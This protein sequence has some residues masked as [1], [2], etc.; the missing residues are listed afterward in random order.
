MKTCANHDDDATRPQAHHNFA[1]KQIERNSHEQQGISRCSLDDRGGPE[2]SGSPSISGYHSGGHPVSHR[3]F[4][5]SDSGVRQRSRRESMPAR[6][7][8]EAHA[9]LGYVH[10]IWNRRAVSAWLRS[11]QMYCRM[12]QLADPGPTSTTAEITQKPMPINSEK[13]AAAAMAAPKSEIKTTEPKVSPQVTCQEWTH[14]EKG[15]TI[16]AEP[17]RKLKRGSQFSSGD[18]DRDQSATSSTIEDSN[19]NSG[20]RGG[21]RDSGVPDR[22]RGERE[23]IEKAA[24]YIMNDQPP[25][26]LTNDQKQ[27]IHDAIKQKILEVEGGLSDL[28]KSF[29]GLE[30]NNWALVND[31]SR[32]SQQSR[33]LDLLEVYR[34]PQS[35]LTQNILR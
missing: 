1:W 28:Q 33:P 5:P 18:G 2:S 4:Q 21:N 8:K 9:D 16:S 29:D 10:Q 23:L 35:Q 11:F 15:K 30:G 20:T 26:G 6:V 7:S 31:F 14:V 32:K 24:R 12:R 19:R 3:R 34:G 17:N 13:P 22:Y 27:Q 25:I